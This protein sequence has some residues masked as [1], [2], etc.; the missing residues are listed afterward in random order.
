MADA[1]VPP[2]AGPAPARWALLAGLAALVVTGIAAALGV[3]TVPGPARMV[4]VWGGAASVA[5]VTA[6]VAVAAYYADTARW[7]RRR[8]AALEETADG[9]HQQA[10]GLAE[11]TL[12]AVAA[13]LLAGVPATTV[14]AEVTYPADAALRRVLL[15]VTRDLEEARHR[16]AA[17]MSAAAGAAARMQAGTTRMLAHLRDLENRYAD[18]PVFGGLLDLDH[19]VSQ[20][21]RL[22]DSIALLSGGRSGRRW[23]R[24]IVMESILRGAAGRID[25]YRRVRRQAVTT[26]AVSGHAAEGVMH[27]LAELMDNATRFSA[28]GSEVHV[29]VQEAD[30]G[31]LILVEDD[32]VGL[33]GRGRRRAEALVAG[34]A[35]L[36]T[37]PGSGLGLASVGRVAARYGLTVS[38]RPSAQG[39]TTAALMIPR[40][41]VVPVRPDPEPVPAEPVTAGVAGAAA[42]PRAAEL[43][44]RAPGRTLPAQPGLAAAALPPDGPTPDVA[45]GTPYEAGRPPDPAC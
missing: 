19:L 39:G 38:F 17:A 43:P 18:G 23:T 24:P 6:A 28:A 9:L 42:A 44:R 21:G 1:T 16:A 20:A 3:L 35:D 14:L 25:G 7:C 8:V 33:R 29:S 36:S 32:G 37:L 26:L 12:P 30:A 45:D 4:T 15:A 2:A 40:P 13:R 34:P 10:A 41:L 11:H 22:A 31:L 5:A 27:A